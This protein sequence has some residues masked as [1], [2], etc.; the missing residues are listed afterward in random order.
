MLNGIL[1]SARVRA[2]PGGVLSVKFVPPVVPPTS[3]VARTY[4]RRSEGI[5]S[6]EVGLS[7]IR[8]GMQE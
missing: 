2:N 6:Q 8:L 5:V 4:G 1:N 3:W 7:D